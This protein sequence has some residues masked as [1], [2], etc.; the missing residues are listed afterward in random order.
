V[1]TYSSPISNVSV[2]KIEALGGT[3]PLHRGV[4]QVREKLIR[5]VV[6]ACPP[7]KRRT[8]GV[9]TVCDVQAFVSER[10][11]VLWARGKSSKTAEG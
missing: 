6:A 1:P 11:D 3:T 7:L 2:R 10:C 9:S 4:G 8:V 5:I